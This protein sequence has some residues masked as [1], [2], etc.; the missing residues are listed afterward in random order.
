MEVNGRTDATDCVT[1]PANAASVMNSLW[2]NQ[3]FSD[4]T[5][6]GGLASRRRCQSQVAVRHHV[7]RVLPVHTGGQMA[8]VWGVVSQS[9]VVYWRP[10]SLDR[11]ARDR[12]Y[13][14]ALWQ[15]MAARQAGCGDYQRSV[16]L[17][18]RAHSSPYCTWPPVHHVS[19]VSK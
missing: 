4:T 13:K 6:T 12:V 18:G 10:V 11:P 7:V 16:S 14:R 17:V 5:Q 1:F 9:A 8:R 3:P 15:H 2:L 19:A